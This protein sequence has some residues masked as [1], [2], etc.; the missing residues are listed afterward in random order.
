MPRERRTSGFACTLWPETRIVS[1]PEW[2]SPS[3]GNVYPLQLGFLSLSTLVSYNILAKQNKN[4]HT[5][6]NVSP[7]HDDFC[8]LPCVCRLFIT[9][10]VY[11]V[12][13][14]SRAPAAVPVVYI[15]CSMCY[16]VAASTAGSTCQKSI[17]SRFPDAIPLSLSLSVTILLSSM[18]I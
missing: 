6:L 18:Y 4:T 7:E 8:I 1:L 14:K 5:H 16:R 9:Q 10:H 2:L 13:R 17:V 3:R 12:Y 11:K 15:Y